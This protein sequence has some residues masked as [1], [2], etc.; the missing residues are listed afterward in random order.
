M[1]PAPAGHPLGGGL[2]P[3]AQVET[4]PGTAAQSEGTA[5]TRRSSPRSA[6]RVPGPRLLVG[7]A[8]AWNAQGG[9]WE[10]L[11]PTRR[12][13]LPAPLAQSVGA[14]VDLGQGVVDLAEPLLQ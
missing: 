7:D 2:P 5:A 14:A 13:V 8:L 12:N 9:E 6:G 4:P 10:N 11:Q 1:P 3:P